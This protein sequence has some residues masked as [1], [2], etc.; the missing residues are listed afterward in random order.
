MNN[1]NLLALD[2]LADVIAQLKDVEDVEEELTPEEL[3]SQRRY[4]QIIKKH[5]YDNSNQ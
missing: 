5:K 2:D 4:E 3:A 1:D